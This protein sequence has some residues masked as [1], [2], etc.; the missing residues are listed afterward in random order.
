M[1]S[2]EVVAAAAARGIPSVVIRVVSDSVER[3]LPDFNRALK[4]DGEVNPWAMLRI[5]LGSPL[6]T[7]KLV[8]LNRKAMSTLTPVLR[9]VLSAEWTAAK[10]LE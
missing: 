5:V 4:P 7:A 2:Y 3:A 6:R 10:D 8:S 9:A 1:E